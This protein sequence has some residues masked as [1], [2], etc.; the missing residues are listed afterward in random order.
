MRWERYLQNLT[1]VRIHH[2]ERI[3]GFVNRKFTKSKINLKEKGAFLR[4]LSFINLTMLECTATQEFAES[5]TYVSIR[6]LIGPAGP[7]KQETLT[8]T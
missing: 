8:R 3:R 7:N 5:L 6:L 4:A 1:Q 2:L